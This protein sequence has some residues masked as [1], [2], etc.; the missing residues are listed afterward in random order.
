MTVKEVAIE[1]KQDSLSDTPI[2]IAIE[3]FGGSGKSTLAGK[4]RDILGDAYVVPLDDFII[5]EKVFDR[6]SN[7]ESFD[8]ARLEAQVLLPIKNGQPA[9]YQTMIWETNTLSANTEVPKV[10]YLIIEGISSYHPDV[11]DYYDYKI[12][13]ETPP[14]TAKARGHARDGSNENA[15]YWD[16][17]SDNDVSYQAKYRPEQVADFI[18]ENA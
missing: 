8:K 10:R 7:M 1:I 11:R 4:L 12:W 5:K 15:Q 2:M 16:L 6:S 13:V 9:R 14:E 17:W 18:I 3:G